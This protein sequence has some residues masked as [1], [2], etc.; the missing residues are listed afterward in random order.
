MARRSPIYYGWVVLMAAGSSHVARN[1]A[2]SLT[3]AVFMFPLSDELGW[4]RTLIAGAASLGGLAATG[5]S[6]IVGWLVDKY[7]AKLVL[8]VS[9]FVLGLSTISLAW[10]TIPVAFYLA[11]ATGRV[12]FSSS[13][14]IGASVVVSRWFVRARGRANGLLSLSH[15]VGMVGFPLIASLIIASQGWRTAWVVLG[16]L[17]WVI[18]LAPV[19]LLIAQRPEDVGLLPDGDRPGD[20]PTDVDARAMDEPQWTSRE[21]MRTSALWTLAIGTGLLF[22]MQSGTNIHVAAYFRDQGLSASIA[23]LAIS[24]N[25]AFTGVGSIAWGWIVDK[26]PARFTLAGVALVMAVASVMMV[27]A[28]TTAEALSYSALFGLG[29]GGMLVVPPVAYANY[30]GRHSLGVIRGLTEPFSS[31]GQ[32][33]GALLSGAIFD[34]TGSYFIAFITFA[35]IGVATMVVVMLAKPPMH[36]SEVPKRQQRT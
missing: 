25:A 20:G 4:S 1:A 19:S 16:L 34:I 26:V 32:A 23:G 28:D 21:A 14:Q 9:I 36:A 22:V 30:F 29:V 7:G 11:Y 31:M 8:A 13:I 18:A 27:T 17:V 10:A 33:F 15:S 35:V 5:T 6:P 2:A 3:I 12:I 24:F